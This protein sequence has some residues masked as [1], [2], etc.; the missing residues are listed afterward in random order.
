MLGLC[1]CVGFLL[2]TVGGSYSLAVVCKLLIAMTSLAAEHGLQGTGASVVVCKGSVA[3]QHLD[4]SQTRDRT[5]VPCIDR[6][7][8]IHVPPGT[9]LSLQLEEVRKLKCIFKPASWSQHGILV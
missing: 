6:W 8:P 1:C 2:V 4:S 5:H 3:L 7:I 9:S